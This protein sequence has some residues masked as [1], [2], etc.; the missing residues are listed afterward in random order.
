[1]TIERWEDVIPTWRDP[2]YTDRIVSY[3][4]SVRR[5]QVAGAIVTAAEP[6]DWAGSDAFPTPTSSTCSRRRGLGARLPCT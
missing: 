5:S 1:M 6:V 2:G 3:H 4:G